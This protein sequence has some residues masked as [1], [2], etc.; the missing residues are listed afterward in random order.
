MDTLK[1][2]FAVVDLS[3]YDEG[4]AA[5]AGADGAA[6]DGET[7]QAS[8]SPAV[9]RKDKNP[10]ADVRYGKQVDDSAGGTIDAKTDEVGPEATG[11]QKESSNRD[12]AKEFD[13]LVKGE[14]KDE[15]GR[16]MQSA[17][18]K[19]F[20]ETKTLKSQLEANQVIVDKL[21]AK[22]GVSDLKELEAA[23][24][25]DNAAYEKAASD[26][27]MSV[28]A[29]KQFQQARVA[30]QRYQQQ[31]AEA[32]KRAE[33]ERIFNGWAQEAQEL[34]SN[35]MYAQFDLKTEVNNPDFVKLLRSGV[36]VKTAYD[37]IH[38]DEIMQLA[39]N[40]AAQQAQQ[41]TVENIRQRKARPSENGI[42]SAA[43]VITKTDP[44]TFSKAD[45][46]EIMRRV[47]QGER[48]EL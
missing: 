22:Y 6:T 11:K 2:I 20:S 15:F 36:G 5:G 24:D 43:P 9:K 44:K 48:I 10:L 26:M 16:R 29:Y 30:N 35:P 21:Y 23:I 45:R 7:Q 39:M 37:V 40:A 3:Q 19:R 1:Q 32:Q 18:D 8:V 34:K 47:A 4:A 27:G 12:L 41:K 17:I 14:Y 46:A 38:R 25:A 31:A 42:N 33:A 28:E 13:E